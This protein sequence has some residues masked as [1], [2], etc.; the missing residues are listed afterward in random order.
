MPGPARGNHAR[1]DKKERTMIEHEGGPGGPAGRRAQGWSRRDWMGTLLASAALAACGGGSGGG[2][3]ASS[4]PAGGGP[5]T[6]T[7][8]RYA[9]DV[10]TATAAGDLAQWRQYATQGYVWLGGVATRTGDTFHLYLRTNATPRGI[11][12]DR[13]PWAPA[14]AAALTGSLNARGA[15]G[16]RFK[17]SVVA[18]PQAL[19][20]RPEAV[21][22]RAGGAGSTYHYEARD[23][24]A[25]IAGLLAELNAQGDRGYA[26]RGGWS[27]T[28]MRVL[29]L[30]ERS[31]PTVRYGYRGEPVAPMAAS[32]GELEGLLVRHGR[33]GARW[34]GTY[35]AGGAY[36][37]L[38]EQ[39]SDDR[40][41]VE[42]LLEDV[43]ASQDRAGFLQ[44]L[45]ARAAGGYFHY[46]DTALA[47]AS[48]IRVYVRGR[49][50][51]HPLG[52]PAY[53]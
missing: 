29:H 19:P 14:D 17:S 41:P 24:Q 26:F 48:V 32:R 45:N 8:G 28:S 2:T 3:D 44:A 25:T 11:E 5:A 38:F 23:P 10:P 46:A 16:W 34:I 40:S 4:P 13:E 36:V 30:Y 12:Y 22:L 35:T 33:E 6:P 42:Y 31:A 51:P 20:V 15:Q 39:R 52:G 43:P 18:D 50:L 1:L 49:V 9:A 27:T 7:E 47:D 37:A 21:F 53:P